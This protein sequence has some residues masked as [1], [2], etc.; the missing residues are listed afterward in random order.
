MR[1]Y[2]TPELDVISFGKAQV[3]VE[4]S[5]GTLEDVVDGGGTGTATGNGGE[6]W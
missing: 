2:E 5:S 1:K 4:V 3:V 6:D